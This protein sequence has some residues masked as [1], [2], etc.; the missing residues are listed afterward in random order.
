MPPSST[1]SDP[2]DLLTTVRQTLTTH[3][4]LAAED[5]VLVAVS[6]GPDSMALLHLLYRLAPEMNFSLGVAHLNH[7]LRGT[8]ADDDAE[9]VRQVA[10]D[11]KLVSHIGRAR[12]RNVKRRLGLSL[13]EAA[14]RVR[15]AFL[16]RTMRRGG[17]TKLAT[18][19]HAD[20]N[21]EQVLMALL[22]GTGPTGLA[23]ILPVRES[24]IIRPL[25]HARRSQIETF[26]GRHGLAC[27]HDATNDDLRI[28][29]NRVRHHLLPLLASEYQ[30]R[31]VEGLNRLAEMMRSEQTWIDEMVT[32]EY[33]RIARKEATDT[34]T[35][36]VDFLGRSHPAL[37]RR[38]T[39][40]ALQELAG[41]LR[42]IRFSHIQAV[43][44]LLTDGC[45]AK[46]LHLPGGI[47][48][49]RTGDRLTL[50]RLPRVGRQGA[51]APVGKPERWAT[52]IPTSFPATVEIQQ[53]GIGMRFVEFRPGRLRPWSE[54]GR[55]EAY[56]DLARLC[57][58]LVLR[59]AASGDRFTP[60]GA[61]GS[62]KLK[63]F[64]TDH[65]IPRRLRATIPVLADQQRIVWLV[66]QR[67]DDHPKVTATTRQ[68]LRVEFFLL[69]A[70]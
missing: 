21:A 69:E 57:L 26:I 40:K 25:S 48:V 27:A 70:R 2:D 49:H 14:R 58:P 30:P 68:V 66:G 38:L 4:M 36:P 62:Q 45:D 50:L 29:R 61:G 46:Q 64:L 10:A 23:G 55:N 67:M 54:V 47:C 19:H 7:C 60:L 11:L 15:Y 39:R 6:G 24:R 28:V 63:K 37:A 17:F 18:G 43:L 32:V 42:R 41:T 34:I 20:D 59:P 44:R 35:L 1:P 51:H 31:I 33:Q 3:A 65:R 16:N 22:R 53:L 9:L 8:S 52:V 56:F 12:V 13:E 5:R